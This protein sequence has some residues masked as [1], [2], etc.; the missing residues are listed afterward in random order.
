MTLS[1]R[2]FTV[3]KLIIT[4]L[5]VA[6]LSLLTQN[7]NSRKYDSEENDSQHKCIGSDMYSHK[8]IMQCVG[9]L[10]VV[11]LLVSLN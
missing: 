6:K 2:T 10:S 8:G 9:V 11:M 4:T 3:T 5:I 1:I 7:N